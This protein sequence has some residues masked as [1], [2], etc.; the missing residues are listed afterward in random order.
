MAGILGTCFLPSGVGVGAQS[1][2]K[3]ERLRFREHHFLQEGKA[4]LNIPKL[5]GEGR[6]R[7]GM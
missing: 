1:T 7:R 6:S 5:L 4:I 2:Q 3:I